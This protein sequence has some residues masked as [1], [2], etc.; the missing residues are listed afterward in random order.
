M[1]FNHFPCHMTIIFLLL[2]DLYEAVMKYDITHEVEMTTNEVK[3][4]LE[5]KFGHIIQ[6]RGFKPLIWMM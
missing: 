4:R 2:W 6:I 1:M 5:A 3:E